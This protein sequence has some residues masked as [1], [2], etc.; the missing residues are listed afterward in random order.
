MFHYFLVYV[1]PKLYHIDEGVVRL[2]CCAL[3]CVETDQDSAA[4]LI[5]EILAANFT[6]TAPRQSTSKKTLQ[7]FEW[8]PVHWSWCGQICVVGIEKFPCLGL[9]CV[10]KKY[11]MFL[12][13]ICRNEY[14]FKLT[15]SGWYMKVA[16]PMV[17]F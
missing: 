13:G 9:C 8:G 16:R 15:Y 11:P 2:V 3:S 17:N 12:R 6:K 14:F 7:E 5:F 10:Y 1:L 4:G